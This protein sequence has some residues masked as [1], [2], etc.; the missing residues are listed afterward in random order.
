MLDEPPLTVRM[1]GLAGFMDYPFVILQTEQASF[2]QVY[3]K[4][5][6]D[7]LAGKT[8]PPVDERNTTFNQK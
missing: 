4:G 6:S 8:V 5:R 2:A 7:P 3:A 1:C